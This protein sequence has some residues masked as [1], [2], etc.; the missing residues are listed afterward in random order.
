[1]VQMAEQVESQ[2]AAMLKLKTNPTRGVIYEHIQVTPGMLT[3]V[4]EHALA[5]AK[6]LRVFE[7]FF[8]ADEAIS[9]YR[10]DKPEWVATLIHCGP[11]LNAAWE[12]RNTTLGELCRHFDIG[13]VRD[14]EPPPIRPEEDR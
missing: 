7:S 2:R 12:H 8:G 13:S 3:V 6:D 4:G 1:M 10:P 14:P 11:D 9:D 5:Q